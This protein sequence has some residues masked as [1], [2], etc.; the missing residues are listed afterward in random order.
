MD[1][2]TKI[3]EFV[4]ALEGMSSNVVQQ[5][6]EVSSTCLDELEVNIIEYIH[7]KY[8][9]ILFTKEE[10]HGIIEKI[11]RKK[12]YNLKKSMDSNIGMMRY[13]ME[14]Q[15]SDIDAIILEEIAKYKMLFASISAGTNISYLGLV[16]ECSQNIMAM[17]IRKNTSLSFAK[18]TGEV[19]EYVYQLVND[20]F[21]KIMVALGDNFLDN[22]ILPIEEDFKN[23]EN[24]R[25]KV[26]TEEFF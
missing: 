25:S 26:K 1:R 7:T 5:A 18:R 19:Q 15:D 10:L 13:K 16:D 24:G 12:H 2:Q 9:T 21:L 17:L 23:I 4:L 6:F 14:E 11:Y 3:N 22:G 20:S 8:P